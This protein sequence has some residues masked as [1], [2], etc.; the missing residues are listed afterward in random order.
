MPTRVH[1]A[2]ILIVDD[3]DA[4]LRLLEAILRRAGYA[5]L[6]CVADARGVLAQV[7]EFQ[8]DLILLDLRMPHE[9]G[10]AVMEGLAR[11]IPFGSDVPVLVLTADVSSDAKQRALSS[12]AKDFLTKPFDPV[13]VVL[14]SRNLLE[15]RFLHLELRNQNQ[16]LEEKVRERTQQLEEAH[17]EILERLAIA[18][19]YRDDQTGQHI[20]RVGHMSAVLARGLGLPSDQAALI[21]RAAPLHDVGKIGIPDHILRKP[22]ALTP[23]EFEIVKTHT[24]IGASI[25]SGGRFPLLQM[26]EE[27][28][29]SHHERWDGTGYPRG[30]KGE[31]IPLSGR[32]V[33]I[34]DVFDAVVSLRPY[35]GSRSIEQAVTTI[36]ASAGTQF[37]PRVVDAFL[38]HTPRP[39][40]ARERSQAAVTRPAGT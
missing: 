32:I 37:D 3:Q 24:T 16:V 6:K 21:E 18:A 25:L 22:G 19:E 9:D 34:A 12:G 14:R 7:V 29:L 33:A 31:A 39:W 28:A 13:E 20:K 27:I 36:S 10:F 8:P 4:N 40:D 1:E 30:L 2:R 23:E 17:H 11:M 26:A 38:V 35:K 5:N 15:T